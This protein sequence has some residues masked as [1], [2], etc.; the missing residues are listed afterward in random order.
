MLDGG[1]FFLRGKT[2]GGRAGD[3]SLDGR[4]GEEELA[5]S[6]ILRWQG[7]NGEAE[8]EMVRFHSVADDGT[9]LK[10]RKDPNGC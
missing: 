9:I 5:R 8:E 2:D 1:G 7:G 6:K 10:S 4:G 3:A